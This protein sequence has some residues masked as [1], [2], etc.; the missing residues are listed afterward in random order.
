MNTKK[1]ISCILLAG[2]M[3]TGCGKAQ[4]TVVET[5]TQ[6]TTETTVAAYEDNIVIELDGLSTEAIVK[7]V[8]NTKKIYEGITKTEYESLFVIDASTVKNTIQDDFFW[9]FNPTGSNAYI[10]KLQIQGAIGLDNLDYNYI[11]GSCAIVEL[12][13]S[14]ETKATKVFNACI[15]N[16][17]ESYTKV[18]DIN[19]SEDSRIVEFQADQN[20]FRCA[21]TT[22]NGV[23][24]IKLSIPLPDTRVIEE[25]VQP[26][27]E[28]V[29]EETET[30]VE[31]EA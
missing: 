25:D 3:L 2:L 19:E 10:S 27:A 15:N 22:Y 9:E 17:E 20:S 4:P 1:F 16:I 18:F 21:M 7:T 14:D 23:T 12:T 30:A 28:P 13:I 26:A 8:N 24:Q 11:S 5:T 31:T 29:I 6:M